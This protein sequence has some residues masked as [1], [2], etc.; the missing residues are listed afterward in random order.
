MCVGLLDEESSDSSDSEAGDQ[1][2]LTSA[3]I[4][5]RGFLFHVSLGYVC[6]FLAAEGRRE[7]WD[8]PPPAVFCVGSKAAPLELD[9]STVMRFCSIYPLGFFSSIRL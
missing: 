1:I 3:V 8:I 4:S 7:G 6:F 9:S 2:D 5:D